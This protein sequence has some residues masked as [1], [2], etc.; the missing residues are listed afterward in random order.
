MDTSGHQRET[1]YLMTFKKS[2][3]E[4]RYFV[5]FY[6]WKIKW[7]VHFILF[8]KMGSRHCFEFIRAPHAYRRK[9][10]LNGTSVLQWTST[11]IDIFSSPFYNYHTYLH[12]YMVICE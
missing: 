8:D 12:D 10:V 2:Q 7:T 3:T 4:G 6:H 1:I 9:Y 11:T 5:L